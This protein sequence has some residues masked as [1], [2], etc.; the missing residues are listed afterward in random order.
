VKR[1]WE[2]RS[3]EILLLIHAALLPISIAAGQIWAYLFALI[4]IIGCGRGSLGSVTRAPLFTVLALFAVAV[5]ASLFVGVRPS[6]GLHKTDRLLLLAVPLVFPLLLG[7]RD[8][9][10][11][12]VLLRKLI[13]LFLIGCASKAAYDCVR[14]PVSHLLELRAY[15]AG[16]SAGALTTSDVPPSLFDAGNM[17]DPQFYA[18]AIALALALWLVRAPGFRPLFLLAV[19]AVAALAL[20]LHF[21]RGAWFSAVAAVL[22]L[23]L[24]T[25]RRRVVVLLLAL[26]IAASFVPSVRARVGQLRDEFSVRSG[27]R[28]SLWT[29]VAPALFEEY[30]LGMGWRSVLHE[31]MAKHRVPV[32]KKLN[33]L[34][35]NAMQVRLELG[36]LG[37]VSWLL[38]MGVGFVYLTRAWR[39]AERQWPSYRGPALGLLVAFLT[40]HLNGLVEYNFGD[41]E[42]FMLMNLILAL[43]VAGWVMLRQ[44]PDSCLD[45]A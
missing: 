14:I 10:T 13:L 29:H 9:T 37:E 18:I 43:G 30:P 2:S 38:W 12:E 4:A 11:S 1:A 22:V 24:L 44:P 17:R 16:L 41:G 5:F 19:L 21:K 34:H 35:N 8:A 42:I 32:Q 33:H 40:L 6:L 23:S 27:G 39:C 7:K 26:G 36:W 28:Y 31:D 15:H 3:L 25:N 20:L 45:S